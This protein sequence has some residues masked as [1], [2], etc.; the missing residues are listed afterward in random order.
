[1]TNIEKRIKMQRVS[2][3]LNL[4]FN[5]IFVPIIIFASIFTLSVIF[6]KIKTGV[7][8]VF[9]YTQ[10]QIVSGSMQDAGFQIGDKCFV[11]SVSAK[12]LKVGD[13]IAFFQFADLDCQ[14][15]SQVTV[16]N[17]PDAKPDSTRIIFH[18]IISVVTD[19]NGE[20][21]FT[22]KGTNNSDVDAVEIHQS[23]V[24]GRY[25][26]EDNFWT[27]F[28]S[29]ITSPLGIVLIVVIPCSLI[30]AVDMYQLIVTSYEYANMKKQSTEENILD[31]IVEKNM[32]D[33]KKIE[34]KLNKKNK[35]KNKT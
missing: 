10:I 18:E 8:S 3:I 28:I 21:W 22:T 25:V 34:K 24:V 5:I 15:P 27:S 14:S 32:T 31:T 7:P 23:Y 16:N 20:K 1:M 29:F 13:Y 2:K 33:A 30:I 19:L 12:D 17:R 26:E 4:I 9:G 35:E 6:S 11:Q